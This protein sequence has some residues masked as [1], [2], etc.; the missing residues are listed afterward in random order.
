[1]HLLWSFGK[2]VAVCWEMAYWDAVGVLLADALCLCLTLL[3]GVLVLKL[4]SH[5]GYWLWELLG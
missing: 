1:M 5:I 3:E 2:R 4:G